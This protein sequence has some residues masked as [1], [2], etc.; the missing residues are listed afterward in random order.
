VLGEVPNVGNGDLL[1]DPGECVTVGE[2]E[3]LGAAVLFDGTLYAKHLPD[4]GGWDTDGDGIPN[5]WEDDKGLNKNDP[6]DG[7]ADGD[8]DGV[9]SDEEYGADTDPLNGDLYLHLIMIDE[10]A[11]GPMFRWIGGQSVT[12]YLEWSPSIENAAWYLLHMDSP[13]TPI[14]NEYDYNGGIPSKAYIRVRTR[15]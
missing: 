6:A 7:P 4:M 15:R 8:G 3:M 2:I 10:V 12:Q 9:P 5:Y 13:P 1:L 14:T 11:D